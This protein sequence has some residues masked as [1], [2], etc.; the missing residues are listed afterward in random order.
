MPTPLPATAPDATTADGPRRLAVLGSTGSVGRQ[1]LEVVDLF[2]ER[3]RVTALA[4]GRNV[5]RLAAQARAYRPEVVALGHAE[6]AGE[7]RAAL[8]GTG[9]DVVAG[10]EGLRAVAARADLDVVLGAI[11]GFAG[12]A[13]VL[14]ALEAGTDV[15]LANKET[16]VVAGALVQRTLK[17]HGATLLPVDSEHSAIFQCLTGEPDDAVEE[18]ILTASGGPFRTRDRS[19]FDQITPQEALNHPNWS[20]GAKITVDS[21]TLMNKGLEVVEGRWLFDLAPAQIR[22]VVHPQS[23]IHSM[24]AFRDGAVKAQLGVPDMKVPIQYALSY[25]ARWPAPHERMDW[26]AL[27]RLDFEPP[28]TDAFPCLQLAY[29]ALHAGGTAPAVLNAA[30]EAAVALFLDEHI[31]FL[32]IPRAIRTAL[33]ALPT[34]TPDEALTY[35]ALAA[36]DADARRFVRDLFPG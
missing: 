14:A 22:V 30:N 3:F 8:A 16:L 4:A 28:D 26:D 12:L 33:D 31:G 11:T 19:T 13:P 17:A 36:A 21:A 32:D 2:P 24:V 27:R 29:D 25:P 15:A 5:E 6:R 34:D 7:L 35:D 23:I 1:T 18:I 10:P 20:M 9:V